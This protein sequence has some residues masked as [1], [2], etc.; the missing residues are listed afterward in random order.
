MFYKWANYAYICTYIYG[1]LKIMWNCLK[2]SFEPN[3]TSAGLFQK[4]TNL[5]LKKA[6]AKHWFMGSNFQHSKK[7]LIAKSTMAFSIA[8]GQKPQCNAIQWIFVAIW[9]IYNLK[10]IWYCQN[11]DSRH[12]KLN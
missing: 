7:F 2:Q 5:A 12:R 9:K 4:F 8:I 6:W 3:F 1:N 10:K 11:E